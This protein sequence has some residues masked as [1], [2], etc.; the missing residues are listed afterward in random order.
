MRAFYTE[1]CMYVECA[2]MNDGDSRSL[3]SHH[4]RAHSTPKTIRN[5]ST[6][7][8]WCGSHKGQI[9][10]LGGTWVHPAGTQVHLLLR[11][12]PGAPIRPVWPIR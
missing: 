2:C 12:P 3:G 7:A 11:C 10:R 5:E 9:A 8:A 6:A 1:G 4:A